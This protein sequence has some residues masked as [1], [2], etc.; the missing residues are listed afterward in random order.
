MKLH[1]LG[2]PLVDEVVVASAL[3]YLVDA[4]R[5]VRRAMCRAAREEL[6]HPETTHEIRVGSR[7]AETALRLLRSAGIRISGVRRRLRR[8]R[9]ACGPVRDADI[10]WEA[11]QR[12]AGGGEGLGQSLVAGALVHEQ[13]EALRDFEVMIKKR[14]SLTRRLQRVADDVRDR[15]T[16]GWNPKKPGRL[17]RWLGRQVKPWEEGTPPRP[18]SEVELHQLRINSKRLRYLLMAISGEDTDA[19]HPVVDMLRQVQE[20]L[21]SYQDAQTTLAWIDRFEEQLRCQSSREIEE[22]RSA[23]GAWRAWLGEKME[24]AI[25]EFTARHE[26]QRLR[27]A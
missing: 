24:S 13:A 5:Q 6:Y 14:R 19:F 22:V 8:L 2:Q 7:K 26:E 21:G 25:K 23:L 20:R 10:R 3:G 1:I 16:A 11:F 4:L 27:L 9:R 18:S 15:L 17:R 12:W